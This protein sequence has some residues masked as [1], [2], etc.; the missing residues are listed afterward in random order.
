[1][2]GA[3]FGIAFLLVLAC[4]GLGLLLLGLALVMG[5]VKLVLRIA[6]LPVVLSLGLLKLLAAALAGLV[7]LVVLV[8]LAPVILAAVAVLAVPVLVI[9]RLGALA[10][11]GLRLVAAI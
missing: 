9:G 10:W 8:A 1:M 6:L 11:G 5:L 4:V 2:D 3:M 7:V